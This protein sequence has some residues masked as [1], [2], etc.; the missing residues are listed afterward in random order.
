[1]S[2]PHVIFVNRFYW[3]DEPATAQLLHDLARAL[4]ARGAEVVVLARDPG[5]A[6]V[7]AAELRDG[8]SIRRIRT[9]RCGPRRALGRLLD[10]A[11]FYPGAVWRLWR[12]TRRGS[13]IVALTDPPL[14][15]VVAAVVARIRR[16]RLV[17]WVQ[18]I[19]PEIAAD[20]TGHR[21]LL[22]CRP[23]RDL[24]WRRA[25]ACVLPGDDMAKVARAAGVP[26]Q[27]LAVAANWAPEGLAPAPA[28]AVAA[29]RQEW[30]LA[31]HFVIAYSGNLGRVHDLDPVLDLAAE[32]RPDPHFQFLFVGGGAQRRGLQAAARARQLDQVH[33][34]PA[35]PR[36][37]LG[38]SL[39]AADLHLVT[40]RPGAESYVFPSKLYGIT[41]VGRPVLFIGPRDCELAR[42]I[43][44][45]GLGATFGRDEIGA[46][47]AWLRQVASDPAAVEQM[48]AA[49]RRFA[50]TGFL[51]AVAAW[52]QIVTDSPRTAP[53]T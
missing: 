7:P 19:Y 24:A 3:P 27:R 23:A 52:W 5:V 35:Q 11:T 16:A 8:V 17:H 39:G 31:E 32:L 25:A 6:G 4:A 20:L 26:A 14:I 1:M 21:W 2:R 9:T 13:T 36:A 45:Q 40:L 49:G 43:R 30:G 51:A 18:D 47:A 38:R 44:T 46:M 29:L 15:G 42:I 10:L 33:F 12:C 34:H 22:A 41:A 37:D 50:A 28:S 53:A 48:Q